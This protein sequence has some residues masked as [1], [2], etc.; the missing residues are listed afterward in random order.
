MRQVTLTLA[1]WPAGHRPL[2]L[3][4][5]S[6][7]H[8]GAPFITAEKIDAVVAAINRAKPDAVVLLGDYVTHGV[9]GGSFIAPENLAL[10]LAG[11]TAPLGIYGVLGN[12]DWWLGGPRVR[13]AMASAG[14]AMIDQAAVRIDRPGGAFW[15]VGID[16]FWKGA[17]DIGAAL[18]KVA[19]PAPVILATHNPDLFP[20]VPRRVAL[21]LAGHTHGGQVNLPLL[22][23]L[24]VPSGF[25]ARYAAGHV[26]EGGRNF[27]ITTGLGT[28]I[29][30]VRFRVPP[31]IVLLTIRAA[32]P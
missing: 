12:H 14:I 13:R 7:I 16:D 32:G 28:S 21:A 2:R 24:V 18:A 15:L 11:L 20:D 6:D 30:P 8:A 31:E 10:R 26:V 29:L 19:D 22:G 17:P 3:A 9:V 27:Y 1:D 4:I 5:L 25:G 23:R